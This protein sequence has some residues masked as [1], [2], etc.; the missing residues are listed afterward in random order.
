[1]EKLII[2][3]LTQQP[4]INPVFCTK[5]GYMYEGASIKCYLNINQNKCPFTKMEL[6]FD[7]DF[8]IVKAKAGPKL[9]ST[10]KKNTNEDSLIE[11]VKN[12]DNLTKEAIEYKKSIEALN[13]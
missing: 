4:T 7:E 8:I 6:S 5:T 2:C 13:S 12:L 10:D 9:T 11:I 3:S 1:M